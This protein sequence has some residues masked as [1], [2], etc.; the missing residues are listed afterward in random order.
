MFRK[1]SFAQLCQR[2]L[3]DAGSDRLVTTRPRFEVP[4]LRIPGVHP[5]TLN[6]ARVS[7]HVSA[8]N[9]RDDRV[10]PN[11]QV[12]ERNRNLVTPFQGSPHETEKIVR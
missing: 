8:V 4:Q 6:V 2:S 11:K 7:R 1:P 3:D 5:D 12:V 9:Q 10:A